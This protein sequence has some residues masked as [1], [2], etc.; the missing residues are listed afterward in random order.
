MDNEN[1]AMMS[2]SSSSNSTA[3]SFISKGWREVRDRLGYPTHAPPSQLVQELTSGGDRFREEAPAEAFGV[4]AGVLVAGFQ[5]EGSG[6]V[7][8]EVAASDRFVGNKERD[9]GGGGGWGWS[10]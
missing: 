9:C 5:Q 3:F 1:Q 10:C 8:S 6:K 2:S 7:D 4:S